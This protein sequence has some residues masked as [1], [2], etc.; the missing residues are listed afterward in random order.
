MILMAACVHL[1][2]DDAQPK[3]APTSSPIAGIENVWQVGPQLFSGGEPGTDGL[4]LLKNRG[5]KTI[6]SVDGGPPPVAQAKRLGMR[7]VHIPIGYN[8]IGP[9]QQLLLAQAFAQSA[10]PIYIHCHH[11]KHRGPAAAAIMARFGLGWSA[12]D[13]TAFMQKAGTSKDYAGLYSS[14]RGF[15]VIDVRQVAEIRTPLPESVD[16]SLMVDMMV[17]IDSRMDNL[18]AWASLK[19]GHKTADPAKPLPIDPMGEAVQLRELVRESARL[20]ECRDQPAA[21]TGHFNRLETDLT[22][23]IDALKA[24]QLTQSPL[25][26]A[27]RTNLATILKSTAGHCTA[28]HRSFRDQKPTTVGKKNA[29]PLSQAPPTGR[30]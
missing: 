29:D 16:V 13:A 17:Q 30:N 9:A 27:T 7:Y 25:P 11:G 2:A 28:C 26:A 22:R 5:F 10:K 6:I 24:T 12:D 18:K 14:V 3:A 19:L 21:F 15:Q 23:W 8:G 4:N 1:H 20:P